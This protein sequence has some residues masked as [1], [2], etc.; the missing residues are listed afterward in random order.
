M[1]IYER[2]VNTYLRFL[3]TG[4]SMEVLILNQ[5]HKTVYGILLPLVKGF[6]KV[7]FG[8]KWEKAK[9]L[10]DNYIVLSNHV[11]D[12]DPLLVGVSFPNQ[13]YF[14]ASEHITRWGFAYK[15]LKSFLNPIIR[16]KGTVA[17]STVIDILRKVRQGNSVAVFAEGVRSWDGVTCPILPST[18]KMVKT[19]GCGLV[20]YKIRG[21]YFVSP[22]WRDHGTA[23]GPLYGAPVHVYTKEELKAMT[24]D[25]V[26]KAICDDLY[27]DAYAR[28][29]EDPKAYRGKDLVNGLHNLLFTCPI[30][31]KHNTFTESGNTV[32]CDECGLEFTMDEYGMLS[33]VP[34]KT[35]KEFSDWQKERVAEDVAAN[36][37]YQAEFATLSTIENHEATQVAAGVLTIN[38]E[39]LK[40]ADLEIPVADISDMGIHGRHALVFNVKGTYYELLPADEFSIQQ[41]LLYYNCCKQK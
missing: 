20:T 10:P 32:T 15:L 28:Q 24:V 17:T 8:Y 36:V 41:F 12:Y 6:L 2:F 4:I 13:M 38:N 3:K 26:Y 5:K 18:A 31:G 39:M 30:C 40:C 7:K 1:I 9:N 29:L 34:F 27:E 11:T 25:E 22:G 23:R 19:A 21:G 14:V 37:T 16:Y 35:V 33:G